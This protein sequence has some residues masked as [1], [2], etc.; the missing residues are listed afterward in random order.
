MPK[1]RFWQSRGKTLKAAESGFDALKVLAKA[2]EPMTVSD[3]MKVMG[4]GRNSVTSGYV[5]NALIA[6]HK[7]GAVEGDGKV[8]KL[9]VAGDLTKISITRY[10]HQLAN[11]SRSRTEFAKRLLEKS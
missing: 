4:R 2:K 11:Q 3:M 8:S 1:I 10:G 7:V 5:V 9:R 6:L